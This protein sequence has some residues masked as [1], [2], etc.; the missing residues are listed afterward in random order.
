MDT[1]PGRVGIGVGVAVAAVGF[2]VLVAVQVQGPVVVGLG[3]VGV[4]VLVEV[5]DD[6][7]TVPEGVSGLEGVAVA[8]TLPVGVVFDGSVAERVADNEAPFRPQLAANGNRSTQARVAPNFT[9]PFSSDPPTLYH[10]GRCPIKDTSGA[11][12]GEAWIRAEAHHTAHLF[13]RSTELPARHG[14]TRLLQA[15]RRLC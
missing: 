3:G 8:W 2:A 14:S 1:Y 7:T 9:A 5:R 6:V 13:E 11:L 15:R 12:D 4:G 10:R